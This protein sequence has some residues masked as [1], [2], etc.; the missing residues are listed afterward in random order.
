MLLLS[1]GDDALH[2]GLMR[3]KRV[4]WFRDALLLPDCSDARSGRQ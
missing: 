1:E 3:K 2:L 4:A